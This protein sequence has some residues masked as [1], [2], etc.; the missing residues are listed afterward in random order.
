MTI[1]FINTLIIWCLCTVMYGQSIPP[2]ATEVWEPVP[3]IVTPGVN[4]GSPSDAIVLFDGAHATEW[5]HRD[6]SPAKWEIDNGILIVKPGTGDIF[7]HRKFADCQLHIE[8]QAPETPQ[9]KGQ[10]HGNSGVFLQD[11]Y[12]VQILDSHGDSTY[13]NGQAGAIYKQYIP[14]VNAMNPKESWNVYDIIFKAPVFNDDGIKVA[15]GYITV[16]HNGVL[17]HN[18]AML[19]GTTEYIGMPKNIA[20]GPGSIILQDHGNKVK[21]RNIWIREL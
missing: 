14:L 21:F 19:L 20:H 2:Q 18:H 3:R 10:D 15:P 4:N 8:W 11:R 5:I 16:I 12:E 13:P 9:G 6:G 7:T 1:Q 17:I